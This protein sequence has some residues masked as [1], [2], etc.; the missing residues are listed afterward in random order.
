MAVASLRGVAN[1]RRELMMRSSATGALAV[2]LLSLPSAAQDAVQWDESEGG[3]GHWYA[4]NT[5]AMS[6][7][8]ANAAANQMGGHLATSTSPEENAFL[9]AFGTSHGLFQPWIGGFQDPAARGYVEP[10]GGWRWVTG[11]AWSYTLWGINE[12]DNATP[13]EDRLEFSTIDAGE[14]N[15]L[16][17]SAIHVSI[18]EWSAD[19]NGDGI[20][21]YGQIQSGE[22]PDAN[23]NNIPDCCELAC[24]PGDL[25]V[26][27]QINGADLAILLSQWGPAGPTTVSDIDGSGFVDGA[28]LSILLGG[29]GPCP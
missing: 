27:Q 11:E 4:A 2:L 8:A 9:Y 26:D 16:P 28:D 23:G 14:W 24:C 12:P 29:W 1:I 3:N 5:S 25:F 15:D 6:W 10:A 18:I 19:C 20:V 7:F 22:L 21:D 13:D 17:A